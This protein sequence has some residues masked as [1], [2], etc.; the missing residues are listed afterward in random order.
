MSG[1]AAVGS[2]CLLTM[3]G[4][5]GAVAAAGLHHQFAGNDGSR[6]SSAASPSPSQRRLQFPVGSPM[7]PSNGGNNSLLRANLRP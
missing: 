6:R 5:G 2:V 7:R 3:A 1:E 4:I